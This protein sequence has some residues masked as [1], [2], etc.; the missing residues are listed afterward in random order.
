MAQE[1]CAIC[2]E[3]PAVAR[4]SLVQNGQRRELALCELHYRQLMRQ[5]RMRS[6]LESLFGGGS[7]FDEIFSG[8]GEQSPV[9]PVRAREPEAVDI[10]EYFSKQTTEYLQRAAQVAAEFGKRE[11]DTEHLLY[12][13]ADADVVQAVLKQFGLSPADLKQYIEANAVRGA[14]KGEASEDMTISP[15]VKSAL[16]HAFALSRELGH[17]Y[18]GPEHLL[19]GLA[20][21]PDSF[22]GTLLKKYGLTEQALRQKAVKVVGK[23]AED[24]RVDGP[25]NTPQLDKFSRDLTRLAR[26]GKLDPVIGRSKE[27]ETTIEVLARRKKNNPVLIGEPGVGKTAIV[28]GLAQRMV[29]GEVPE[30]LRDKRLVELNINAMVA[31]AKYRGEFEER[32][33]QVMD[34]LQAAQSE[35]ILFI[36]EVHTIVGAGQGGGEGGLDVA[37]VLKPAMARG[38]MNLIGATTLNEYQKYI[39]KDAALERR[40]QPVFVPEPTVEQTIS[41]LRGLRDKLEGHH[42]VTI[43]DEAFVAAAELSDRYIGNRFLPDKAIDLIDQAAARVRIASTSRPAEIQE[44]EA[45]L[46]QL[47]REQD[48]AA[49]RKWYDEAKVF[50]KRI[51]ER[52]EH[53]EQITERWQQTQGSKTEEVR[54]EDIAEIISR[55]TGIPVTELT[56]EEREKLLQMEER[57]HQRVIGQQ[58]AITAVSDAVRLARAG[59]R[60][61][62]RPIATFL[63]LGPTGVGKT[64]LAKALAE[65]VFGDEDAMIRIDMSEYMERHAVSRLI[66]APPGYVGYDEGGQLTERVR[67]RPYSVILLDEIEKARRRQ[68]HPPAGV[69]R[70]PPDRRQGARGGLH[71]HHHHRH[72]QPRLRADHEERPGRRVRPA[73]GEA[74]ARTDD[75]PARTF[76]PGIPQPPRRGD[77]LRVAEQGA[78]RGHRAPATGAG[79]ARRARSGHLPA[80]RRQ[81]GRPP[82]RRGLPAGVRRPRAEAADPPATG[83]APGHGDAQGRGEGGRDGHLLLRRQGR[84][85]LPQGRRAEAGGTQ[86]VRCRRDTQGPRDGGEEAGGEERRRRQGQGRQAEGQVTRP[87]LGNKAPAGR[88]KSH[89]GLRMRPGRSISHEELPMRVTTHATLAAALLLSAASAFAFNLGDAAKAVAGASQ[90]DSAQVATTPQ[91]SGLLGALTGQLGVSQEQ[92]VGGTGALLGLAKNQLAGNDYSQLVKTIPGLD[93]LAGNNALAGLGGLGNVLGKSGGDSKGLGSLL[94]NA[95]SMGDVNK[96]FGTLGM[97]SGMTE[98]FAQVLV[99]YFG[100]Q[101]ANSELLGSLSNLWG[102]SKAGGSSLL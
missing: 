7:P 68:Q 23:G 42:K 89:P 24:G 53:L 6:P 78:D 90:G 27:V 64:E 87:R 70:R 46:A 21:V 73:A 96:A 45:E 58:E 40:F 60:Q 55:L 72:Q 16:Q 11:V 88:S 54:V 92:A 28:E 19:L 62:S 2:H 91:T 25:S 101:G 66:G 37:N 67:R 65:V 29:Q 52:K 30:V 4:V 35:I 26:E 41:I 71:Q 50:E 17:S 79:E 82:R 9:T 5:Q 77:R 10:A 13:L 75:Y 48:Y 81:P 61:G 44:L 1:L 100:K 85:R 86:E 18:V 49:S 34:E 76:P 95:D 74:Q 57:L 43:R 98:K 14:S 97:D 39:E 83:D 8:F 33:K 80:H 93:K 47:K 102:V 84:R 63:F 59:L 31:G 15:R 51:Q 94:G 20:A 22:A 36:D 56:A 99:D 69:R 38:E 3:R 12:A 32:L